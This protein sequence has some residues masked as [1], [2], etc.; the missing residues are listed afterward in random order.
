[1]KNLIII[2]TEEDEK[3]VGASV[4]SGADA[5]PDRLR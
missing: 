1:M 4:G 5:V 2:N 3:A